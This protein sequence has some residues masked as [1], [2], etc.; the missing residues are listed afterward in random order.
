MRSRS[1]GRRPQNSSAAAFMAADMRKLTC[2]L[3]SSGLAILLLYSL[4]LS[5]CLTR[6]LIARI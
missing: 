4:P 6:A 1:Y 2:T 5:L 3:L